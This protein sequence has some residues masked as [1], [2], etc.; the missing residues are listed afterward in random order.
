M[1]AASAQHPVAFFCAEFGI[2]AKLPIYAG[3]LG[4]L[5][6]DILKEAADEHLP[7]IGVGLLY[8]GKGAIQTITLEGRQL[9]TDFVFD[10]LS[11]GLEHVYVDD[12][13]LFI[14]VHLTEVNVWLRCWQKKISDTV[15]LYLLDPDTEQNEVAQ[16]S[17]THALYAGSEEEIIKQQLLLGIGGVKLLHWLG[18]HPS[19]YH[20]NEGRP[21]FLHWQLVRSYMDESGLSFDDADKMARQ[22]TVYTNHTLVEAGNQSYDP[23]LLKKYC[24]YYSDKMGVTTDQL[25]APG[26]DQS[27]GK[28]SVTNYALHTARKAS[29][30]SQLHYQ[31][32]QQ[33]WPNVEWVGVTNGV[34]PP[35][36]QASEIALSVQQPKE[37]WLNHLHCKEQTMEYVR[38]RTGYGYDTKRLVVTWAR[39]IAGYKRLM[40][41]FDDISQLQRIVS[42]QG[43]EVQLLIAGKAHIYDQMSKDDIEKVIHFMQKELSGHALFV[44]NLDIDL[45]TQLT[46]GSDV[47]LNTPEFGK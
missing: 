26:I 14:K 12:M 24:Q 9:E 37:L 28:F 18:V 6:G 22:K 41:L 42:K 17:I 5:A 29:A 21:A 13:P 35:T 40:R 10:P 2:D 36:W 45:A 31:F 7:Y 25:L 20:I 1:F 3:G 11:V 43:F 23:G 34:H 16:R 38:G 27:T 39:R 8:H 33:K 32:C 47:W 46:R 15:T 4:I 30:V 44:P 19:L